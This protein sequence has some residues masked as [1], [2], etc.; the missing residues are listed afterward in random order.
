[1]AE[2]LNFFEK[3]KSEVMQDLFGGG[4]NPDSGSFGTKWTGRYSVQT[5]LSKDIPQLL[6]ILWKR[7]K[8]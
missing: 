2:F 8:I 6:T 1:L 3:V 5:K 7:V 4:G